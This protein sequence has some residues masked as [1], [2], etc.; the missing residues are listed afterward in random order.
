[1]VM[2]MEMEMVIAIP[3]S[4]LVESRV[5]PPCRLQG[6]PSRESSSDDGFPN[7]NGS[8]SAVAV[9]HASSAQAPLDD[10]ADDGGMYRGEDGIHR[11]AQYPS[12]LV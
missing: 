3:A 8:S 10:P 1:M 12:W 11:C 5:T 7:G 2:V 4:T 9:D 6:L